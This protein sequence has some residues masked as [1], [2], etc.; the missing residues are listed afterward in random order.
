MESQKSA[1]TN[2]AAS[3]GG[4]GAGATTPPYKTTSQVP[5]P[6]PDK[7]DKFVKEF[8]KQSGDNFPDGVTVVSTTNGTHSKGS[9][10][11]DGDAVDIRYNA[12]NPA[13]TMEAASLA[14]AKFGLD[15][16]RHPSSLSSGPHFHFQLRPG[17]GGSMGDLNFRGNR[18]EPKLTTFDHLVIAV[19]TWLPLIGR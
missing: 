6:L 7:L 1:Q 3:G 4:G 9:A 15:E 2:D 12:K 5:T 17:K 11:P 19:S 14:G 16:K 10:H 8:A 13:K 18:V